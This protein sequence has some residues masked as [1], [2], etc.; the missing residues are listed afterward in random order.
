MADSSAAYRVRFAGLRVGTGTVSSGK[1]GSTC[2]VV[3]GSATVT[4][5]VARDLTIAVGDIVLFARQG[6]AWWVLQRLY[7]AAP[8]PPTPPPTPPDPTPEPPPKPTVTTGTLTCSPVETRS[9]RT[10][11]GW[12]SDNTSVYQG[13]YGGWG[14]HRGCAFYGSKPRSLAGA[15]VTSAKISLARQSGGSFAA[16][17][18]NLVLIAEATRPSGTPTVSAGTGITLPK[19][20]A[21][22]T[23]TVPAAYAQ[24][25]VD[26]SQGG[27]G[28]YQSGGSPYART[29]GWTLSITWR[30]G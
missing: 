25:L 24:T 29:A 15:T 11:Y 16:V 12:R 20:G 2:G 1:S 19:V 26:G 7:A 30:R 13:E 17:S 21:S 23:I 28:L 14:N 8:T 10:T 9:W 5:Q 6:S 18:G 4:M 22:S 27:L 3:V